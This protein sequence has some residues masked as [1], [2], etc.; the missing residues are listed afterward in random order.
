MTHLNLRWNEQGLVPAVVVDATT[1][2][3]LMLA[4][5]NKEAL[6]ETL[7][8]GLVHFY[9][10]SR[11]SLWKKGETSGNTLRMESLRADC[12][13]DALVIEAHPA[14]PTCHTGTRSCFMRAVDVEASRTSE[15]DLAIEREDEGPVGACAAVLDRIYNVL[16]E[17]KRS[18]T[19]DKS[20]TRSLLD[21]GYPE[22]EAKIREEAEELIEVLADGATGDVIHETA[23]L[24]FHTMVGLCA[25]GIEPISIW[26]ELT[27]RFGTSGHEEKAAR[28]A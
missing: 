27:R 23:D 5:M 17:R 9:S 2:A 3:T 18:S 25:R 16:E 10:R 28:K 1:H 24:I 15:E 8:S 22:I 20:Y 4:W 13:G 11:Q 14:G 19:G 26:R 12:D 6:A 21:A 7:D